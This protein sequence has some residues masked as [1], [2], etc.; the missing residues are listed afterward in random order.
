MVEFCYYI[1]G[2]K[3]MLYKKNSQK[4]LSKELFKNP[5]SEYR[6]TPFWAWNDYLTKDELS[7]QIEIFNEM[8]LGGF[9]MHVRTGLKNQ[10]LSEEF[11]GLVK[12][13]VEKA[14]DEKMLA[15]LYDEDRWPSGAAGGLVTKD[16]KYR[17]RCL[18]FTPFKDK[19][20]NPIAC[21]DVILD[22]DGFL[23]SYKKIGENDEAEGTKWYAYL[24]I[25]APSPWYNNQT[26]PLHQQHQK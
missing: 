12:H 5:T 19:K 23:S 3:T 2:V 22:N 6:G 7:R 11:M 16:E 9:H 10:Y 1:K 26:Y 4:T 13:C 25:H 21:Y 18:F 8:G 14:K 24:K 17:S 15:W 20:E